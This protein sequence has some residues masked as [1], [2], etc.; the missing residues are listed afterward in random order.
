[1]TAQQTSL[2]MSYETKHRPIRGYTPGY[3]SDS[4]TVIIC[5]AIELAYMF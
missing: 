2:S 4:D 1:M 5:W 3:G